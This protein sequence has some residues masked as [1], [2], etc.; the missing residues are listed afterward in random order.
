MYGGSGGVRD[1][2]A[3]R[4]PLDVQDEIINQT[5]FRDVAMTLE[6]AQVAD[7]SARLDTFLLFEGDRGR[8]QPWR[9]EC[10]WHFRTAK[11]S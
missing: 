4:M 3:R 11:D 8:D 1:I 10:G 7:V 5:P 9:V 2:R 6:S